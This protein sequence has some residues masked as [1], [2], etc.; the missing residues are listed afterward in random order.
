MLYNF[1]IYISNNENIGYEFQREKGERARGK[2]RMR[3]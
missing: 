3:N 2:I 1:N